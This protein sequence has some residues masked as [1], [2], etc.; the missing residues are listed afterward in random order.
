MTTARDTP[1]SVADLRPVDLF[2]DL[3][4]AGLAEFAAAAQWRHVEP[5][6]VVL[7]AGEPPRGDVLPA[8]GD[9]AALPAR[10]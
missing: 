8:R 4:D 1:V 6:T 9:A 3:D 10:R 2:D 5:G 7:E